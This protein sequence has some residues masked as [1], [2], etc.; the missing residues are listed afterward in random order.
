M[1]SHA[2]SRTCDLFAKPK[3]W[4]GMMRRAMK[5]PVGWDL[6]AAAYL[7]VYESAQKR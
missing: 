2:I 4:A 3:I 6:S 1:F 5:H 7:D